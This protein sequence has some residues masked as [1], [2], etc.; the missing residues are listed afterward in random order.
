M[1]RHEQFRLDIDKARTTLYAE[2]LKLAPV[3]TRLGSVERNLQEQVVVD[4]FSGEKVH[5]NML[6]N[7]LVIIRKVLK[8]VSDIKVVF[9]TLI[10]RIGTIKDYNELFDAVNPAV[11]SLKE[12]QNDLAQVVPAARETFVNM[13]DTFSNTLIALDITD[14]P[15]PSKVTDDAIQIL[16]EASSVVEN[17]LKHKFPTLP[18]T[19][20]KDRVPIET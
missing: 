12:L 20:A 1:H 15:S 14:G 3:E 16:E 9:E 19:K 13:S 7:E 2:V 6:A 11:T 17:E 4:V 8:L 5:A 18:E 10:V